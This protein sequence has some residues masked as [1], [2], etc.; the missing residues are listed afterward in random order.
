MSKVISFSRVFPTYHPRKGE[1]TFF[2]E[3]VLNSLKIPYRTQ[4]Y[5]DELVRLNPTKP[6]NLIED[7][8]MSLDFQIDE[9]KG[10]T[11]RATKKIVVVGMKRQPSVWSGKPYASPQIIIAPDIE[12]KKVWDISIVHYRYDWFINT[13]EQ[14]PISIDMAAKNDG[15]LTIDFMNWFK[16]NPNFKGQIICWNENI[17]Y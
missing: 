2:V 5:F 4:W 15:L 17:N 9:E 8:F 1:P 14:K 6:E 12:V 3:K 7:F 10:H 13:K 16:R 11:I